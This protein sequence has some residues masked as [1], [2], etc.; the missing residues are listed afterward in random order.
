[1]SPAAAAFAPVRAKPVP[2][3]V[4]VVSWVAYRHSCA[5]YQCPSPSPSSPGAKALLDG[6]QRLVAQAA[7]GTVAPGRLIANPARWNSY[8]PVI[9]RGRA[10]LERN[11]VSGKRWLSADQEDNA[12]PKSLCGT[13][14]TRATEEVVAWLLCYLTLRQSFVR[15]ARCYESIRP[16]AVFHGRREISWLDPISSPRRLIFFKHAHSPE[17]IVKT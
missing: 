6:S 13:R 5:A 10:G 4:F 15:P 14:P 9:H 8:P 7:P 11:E 16:C 3:A 2:P 17:G 12:S 1:M